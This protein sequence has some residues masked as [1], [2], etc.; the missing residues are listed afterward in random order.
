MI[1]DVSGTVLIPGNHGKDCP[2]NGSD[3]SVEC[4]CDECDYML[5]CVDTQYPLHCYTCEDTH[6]PRLPINRSEH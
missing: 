1:I 3:L 4:C 6:C 2:G 5:C